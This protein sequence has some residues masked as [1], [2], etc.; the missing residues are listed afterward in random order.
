MRWISAAIE[1]CMPY[2]G[3]VIGEY[4]DWTPLHE[5]ERL[6]PEDIDKNDPLAVQER[7]GDLVSL[8]SRMRRRLRASPARTRSTRITNARLPPGASTL[9][10]SSRVL[11]SN[12]RPRGESMLM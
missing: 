10:S 9:T 6:F 4:T 1:I 7:A 2:L 11:R 8:M 5:R 3:P 12:A